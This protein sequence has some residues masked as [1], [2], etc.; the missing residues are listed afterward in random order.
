MDGRRRLICTGFC[1]VALLASA[2]ALFIAKESLY[3]SSAQNHATQEDVRRE[4]GSPHLV[5]T[6]HAGD[7]VWVY[8]VLQE[9]PGAQNRWGAPG[10]WCDEYV[11][12]FDRQGILRHW[13][14]KSEGHG[15]ELMPGY[16]VTDGYKADS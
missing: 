13:T 2:C 8:Q 4:L 3:L 9:E 12:T 11:L 14:H 10:T 1:G 6:S 7:P 15:G 16:C 5:A